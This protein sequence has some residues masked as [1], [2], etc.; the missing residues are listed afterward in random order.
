MRLRILNASVDLY[1]RVRLENHPLYLIATDGGGIPEPIEIPDLLVAPAERFEVLVRG[2]RPPGSYRLLYSAYESVI[3]DMTNMPGMGPPPPDVTLATV[4]YGPRAPRPLQLPARLNPV[5]PLPPGGL[6]RTFE[7]RTR[8]LPG[9]FVFQING[10]DFDHNHV[11]TS[12]LLDTIE[13]WEVFNA[14][15]MDH[16]V[17]LHTNS[18]QILG[19]DGVPERAWRDIMNVRGGMRRRFRVAFRDFVG[20]MVYHCHRVFHGDLG[21]MAV[22][23]INRVPTPARSRSAAPHQH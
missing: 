5:G 4:V 12:V 3:G 15:Q 17:H 13:E 1:Y 11:D 21:M 22:I 14:D 6:L 9:G 2:D 23:E 10:R 19:D 18:F 7:F 8:E 16:P 20:R